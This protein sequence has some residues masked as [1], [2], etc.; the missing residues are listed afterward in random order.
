VTSPQLRWSRTAREVLRVAYRAGWVRAGG[1]NE[2]RA[3]AALV[4]EGLLIV[5]PRY[6][7][8]SI[9][10]LTDAGRAVARELER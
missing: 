9:Y 7:S 10:E 3:T 1:A 5:S 2:R 4:R 6:E 8:G